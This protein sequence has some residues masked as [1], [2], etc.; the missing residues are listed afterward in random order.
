M[1]A[2]VAETAVAPELAERL[3]DYFAMAADHMVNVQG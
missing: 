2:A 1:V 3:L